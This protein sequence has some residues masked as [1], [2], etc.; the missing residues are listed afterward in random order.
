M[1]SSYKSLTEDLQSKR[2]FKMY[3]E[4]NLNEDNI[5]TGSEDINYYEAFYTS[6]MTSVKEHIEDEYDSDNYLLTYNYELYGGDMYM[7]ISESLNDNGS[8]KRMVWYSLNRLFY[9]SQAI[10]Q[11]AFTTSS[12]GDSA[13]VFS[14][15][16]KKLGD[17]IKKGSFTLTDLTFP[18]NQPYSSSDANGLI[19]SD[20]GYGNLKDTN[21]DNSSSLHIGNISYDTGLI[22]F[23]DSE[24]E[25]Y[26]ISA[27]QSSFSTNIQYTTFITTTEYE[28]I[29]VIKPGEFNETSNPTYYDDGSGDPDG[30]RRPIMIKEAIGDDFHTFATGVKLCDES[31]EPVV[32]G[33]FAKPIRI[34]K[35]FDSIFIVKFDM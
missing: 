15:P 29:C 33:K 22:I 21:N 18:L 34:E 12:I 30:I 7:P 5:G 8:E 13:F 31:G 20:D 10:H 16:Q 17:G 26:F 4:W 6:S 14:I 2:S 28:F 3:S 27:S 1:I 25:N 9:S 23:T 35:D 19:I 11:N 32:I 24:Y